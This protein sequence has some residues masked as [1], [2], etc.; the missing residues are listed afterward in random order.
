MKNGIIRLIATVLMLAVL[1]AFLIAPVSAQAASDTG[2]GTRFNIMLVIDGSGSLTSRNAGNTDP[3]GMRY[4]LIGDLFGILEDDGHNIGAIVFSGS[5][6]WVADEEDLEECI[7]LNTGLLSLDK[8]APNGSHPKDYLEAEIKDAGVDTSPHGTTDIGTALLIAE[9][10]LQEAQKQNGL[11]SLIFLFTD[12]TTSLKGSALDISEDNRDT[13]TLEMNNNQIR[14]FGAFLNN[15]GKMDSTE[16]IR[17]VCAA[18]GISSTSP[19]FK[20]SFV[21]IQD[22]ASCHVAVNRF[23]QFLNYFSGGEYVIYYDD[24]TDTFT[25]P[26]VGV[27]ELNIRLY[28]AGGEDLPDLDVEI[29]QPD[30][31]VITGVPLRASRTFRVYKLIDPMP[32]QWRLHITVPENNSLGY[33]YDPVAS[34]DIDAE[35]DIAPDISTLHVNQTA[36]FTGL[37][38]KNGTILTDPA[39][40][41]GYECTLELTNVSTGDVQL[42]DILPNANSVLVHNLLLDT[43]GVFNA[44]VLFSCGKISFPSPVKTLDLLN[45]APTGADSVDLD[46]HYGLFRDDV[47][48]IDLAQYVTDPEDGS[49]LTVRTGSATCDF[50][51]FDLSGTRLTLNNARIGDSSILFTV[52]DSQGS[53]VDLQVNID[54]H[55]VTIWYIIGLILLILAIAAIVIRRTIQDNA[56]KPDGQ[57]YVRFDCYTDGRERPA[58]LELT[59]PGVS[60][61]SKTNLYRLMLKE[62]RDDTRR[63]EC[64]ISASQIKEYLTRYSKE[65]SNVLVSKATKRKGRQN[66]GAIRV[67]HDKKKY[68]LYGSSAELFIG[69]AA[70]TVEFTLSQPDENDDLF[71]DCMDDYGKKTGKK[72]RQEDDPFDFLDD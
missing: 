35:I 44:R 16:M 9:R 39:A 71:S 2:I 47:T 26:G 40:Y 43:Y 10:Q 19:E 18:N 53:G 31:T 52:M 65:L 56:T 57:L 21:E 36:G 67:D 46:I 17:I 30:G 66:V 69:D 29:T 64:G 5:Q 42:Y 38:V 12:G 11:E 45:Q 70:F 13:A 3:S 37:L 60:A 27:E 34:L 50:S 6:K 59:I 24:I 48:E 22:A 33:V 25:I 15:E 68:T 63:L 14:L 49:N 51:A 1:A 8:P 72:P 4:E 32:G 28:S 23:L 7:M 54:T 41:R 61:E 20:E 55:N 58:E 62:L